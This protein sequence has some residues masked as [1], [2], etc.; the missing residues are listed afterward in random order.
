MFFFPCQSM[1][2]IDF[3]M[4]IGNPIKRA[5]DGPCLLKISLFIR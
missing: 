3:I 4:L 2:S 5:L 1:A